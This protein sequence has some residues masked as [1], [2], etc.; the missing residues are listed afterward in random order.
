[1]LDVSTMYFSLG[2]VCF[3]MA[4]TL[5]VLERGRFREDGAREW[6]LG[7]AIQGGYWVLL[8][9]RGIVWDFLSI[10][11]ANLCLA[12]SYSLLYAAV[13]KFQGRPRNRSFLFLPPVFMFL[14]ATVFSVLIDNIFYRSFLV[15]LLSVFQAGTIALILF[16]VRTEE[17]KNSHRLTGL[18]F[19]MAGSFWLIRLVEALA[20]S[21][22]TFSSVSAPR[23]L[24]PSL[25]GGFGVVI[26]AGMGYVLMMRGR[27]EHSLRDSEEQYRRIFETANEGIL[28][29]DKDFTIILANDR[30]ARMVGWDRRDL[31]GTN[32]A[33]LTFEEDLPALIDSRS[34]CVQGVPEEMEGR[35]R[36]K[37]GTVSWF[38]SSTT[39]LLDDDGQ[40]VGA[41]AMITDITARK[42]AE[43]QK[44][45]LEEQLRQAQKMEAIGTL[46]GGVAHDFNNLLTVI[47]GFAQLIQA[48]TDN[49]ATTRPYID[50]IVESSNRAADL[51]RSL[52]AFS[53]KQRIEVAP[54]SLN[55]VVRNA[56]ALL[57]RLLP[58]DI[59][60]SLSLADE[61]LT[62]GIDATQIDQ[63]LMNLAT[64][65]RDAMPHGGAFTVSTQR[66][67]MEGDFIKTHRFGRIGEYAKLSVADNGA[68]MD[69]ATMERIFEPFFT[70][71]EVGKG[72][73]L[74]LASTF[75]IVKQHGGYITVSSK[76][77]QGTTFDIY[78][79]L[80]E[81][82]PRQTTIVHG[83]PG[84]G[85]ETILIVEDD[86]A[87]RQMLGT[88]LEGRGYSILEAVDGNAAIEIYA[89]QRSRIDLVIL[90]VVM[91]G[92]N[93]KD[94]FDEMVRID[95]GVRAIFMSGYTGDVVLTK[96]IERQA[97]DFLQKPVSVI[98]L[99]SKVR[100]VLD[101]KT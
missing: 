84:N 93:G 88:I 71:K 16:R 23:S 34:K 47:I 95:T 2:A 69:P 65:A 27:A 59:D 87:V 15:V 62:V 53:R 29:T 55:D 21:H 12:V 73:G 6:A 101:R 82:P 14:A 45:R 1:M 30:F 61:E 28:T 77:S 31:I 19:A 37:D 35:L 36:Q 52:L 11:I 90:D 46:A 74:G 49:D 92:R 38:H 91:P 18:A 4:A 32:T 22:G 98:S 33:A 72:T 94:V 42:E 85:G 99:L 75:G 86:V 25:V 39:P 20:S 50:Q 58:E 56:A 68:G 83:E 79:P 70:T 51:T 7:W 54:H 8:G 24:I 67:L 41:F 89:D 44:T 66:I 10:V 43:E 78:L 76:P 48:D 64:N 17:E 26:L 13:R 63:V 81:E 100:E 96:G 97:V 5:A 9:L 60:V 57:K 40:F 80:I 3:I